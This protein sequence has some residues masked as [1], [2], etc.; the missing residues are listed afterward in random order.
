MRAISFFCLLAAHVAS[1]QA[2]ILCPRG[3]TILASNTPQLLLGPDPA[4]GPIEL[5]NTGTGNLLV[6]FGVSS[7][8][9]G[10]AGT[11]ILTPG[12][13]YV[14]PAG[15]TDPGSVWI[16]DPNA[17]DPFACYYWTSK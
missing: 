2:A 9:L 11:I 15:K 1:A 3:S 17:G 14:T 5:Q 16:T 12:Q 6:N 7:P 10:S 13:I 8:T 4:R